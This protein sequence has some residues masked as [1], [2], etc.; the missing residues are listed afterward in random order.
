MTRVYTGDTAMR[1][2]A[3]RMPKARTRSRRQFATRRWNING[4][5][6]SRPFIA[7]MRLTRIAIDFADDERGVT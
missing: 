4:P 5:T 7:P 6:L 3:T 2:A 1:V